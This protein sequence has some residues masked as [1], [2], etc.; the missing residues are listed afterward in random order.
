MKKYLAFLSLIVYSNFN[1]S[2]LNLSYDISSE[3]F[4]D[5][6]IIR[7]DQDIVI[8]NNSSKSLDTLYLNDWSN[9]YSGLDSQLALKFAEKFNRSFYYSSNK[10]K[11]NTKINMIDSNNSF[12]RWKRLADQNDIIR[13]VLEKPI[14]VGEKFTLKLN[15]S[16]SIP[17]ISFSG[18]YGI[19]KNKYVNIKD[20][21]ISVSRYENN[22]WFY[23]SN[24]NLNDNSINKSNYM[25]KW[26]YP[27]SFFLY[28]SFCICFARSVGLK[29]RWGSPFWAP[30]SD[31]VPYLSLLFLE[32][33]SNNLAPS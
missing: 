9:S 7:I 20:Y 12:L 33:I 24:L 10:K 5:K 15:Y 23:Q 8:S 22:K 13:L 3:L 26:T 31:G 30:K 1:Y 2:Q 16:V 21:I 32:S 17:D 11:G 28:G 25:I 29:G 27:K 14:R 19:Q 6:K 4:I 18:G